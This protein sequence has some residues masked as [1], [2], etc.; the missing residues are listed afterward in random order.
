[1]PGDFA[2]HEANGVLFASPLSTLASGTQFAY[3]KAPDG[4]LVEINSSAGRAFV[5]VHLMSEH[6]L[7][8]AD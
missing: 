6:P 7:C 2:R 4:A 8:T 1:M 5:H 3:M